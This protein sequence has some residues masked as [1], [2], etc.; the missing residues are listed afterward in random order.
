M[1]EKK[2]QSNLL[3][4]DKSKRRSKSHGSTKNSVTNM[5]MRIDELKSE[6]QNICEM[7]AKTIL[8]ALDTRDNYT[9]NHSLRVCH[10]SLILGQEL[11]LSDS[12]LYDLQLS[13]LFHD[14]GKVGTPDAVLNKPTRLSDT[15]FNIMKKHPQQSYEIL[16]GFTEFERV[17]KSVLHH[18]ERYDGRG[19]PSRFKG[20]E[21]PLFSRIILIA[22]TF[23]AMISDR[24]YRKGLPE[25]TALNELIE[26]SGSQ[27][28]H[29]LVKRFI[30]GMRKNE[31][32]R[33][34]IG[35]AS[36]PLFGK[37]FKAAS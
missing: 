20:E 30:Q 11:K 35:S 21:I 17:A 4:F 13:A 15:E 12:D 31:L 22:D 7:A 14:I 27:F 19:Y 32:G 9:F 28:D 37:R 8:K 23:D 1:K 10:Y 29:G 16:K 5:A 34:D 2:R 18:H 24:V 26:F 6:K 3:N 25:E 36:I 33:D